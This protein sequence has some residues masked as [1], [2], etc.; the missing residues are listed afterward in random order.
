MKRFVQIVG[1][2]EKLAR[3]LTREEAVE[4]MRVLL[5][6]EGTPAQVGGFLIAMR[7]KSESVEECIGFTQ[8][9]RECFDPPALAP[10]GSIDVGAPHDGRVRTAPVTWLAALITAA[11][12]VAT[13]TSGTPDLAPKHG[14][15]IP[16]VLEALGV[17]P[18]AA[19]AAGPSTLDT[20]NLTY[21]PVA[22]WFPEWEAFRSIREELGLRPL[23]STVEKLLNPC[24]ADHAVV[25]VFHK[26][27]LER[28]AETL[29]ALG[30]RRAV[31]VQ[32][33]DGGIVPSVRRKTTVVWAGP[34]GLATEVIDPAAL[35][36]TH[37]SEPAMPADSA[38]IAEGYAAVLDNRPDADP[39]WRDA[40]CLASG[41]MFALAQRTSVSQGFERARE[42]LASGAVR[43]LWER[44]AA[45][46]RS[47]VAVER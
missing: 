30:V 25:G 44:W 6:G 21:Q 31:V 33:P 46:V 41:L 7:V 42:L 17:D 23:Q 14:V 32:G 3:D 36:I 8:G 39:A 1:R 22:Q 19:G 26:P 4:A 34:D 45:A 37:A 28:L 9:A 20:L 35:G 47:G 15:G 16:E 27:Y 13:V 2:G 11:G 24:R 38:A 10:A 18:M 5:A 43:E 29:R 40:A 12:G